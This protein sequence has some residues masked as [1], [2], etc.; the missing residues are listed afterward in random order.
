MKHVECAGVDSA[1]QRAERL[2][3]SQEDESIQVTVSSV[4]ISVMPFPCRYVAD[5][6]SLQ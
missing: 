6:S 5:V 4:T 1:R 2:G 3:F